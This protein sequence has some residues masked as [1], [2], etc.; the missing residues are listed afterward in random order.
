[1]RHRKLWTLVILLVALTASTGVPVIPVQSAT[2]IVPGA[3]LADIPL[4]SPIVEVIARLGAP[5]QVRLVAN[6]GTLAY[7]FGPYAITAYTRSNVVA[8]LATTNSVLAS[9]GGV[10]LGA[11]L[12]AVVAAFGRA[13][14][15]GV[16]EG[17]RGPVYENLGVAFGLDRDAV[18]AV[19][20]FAA[21][22]GPMSVPSPNPPPLPGAA[23]VT[24]HAA[25][26]GAPASQPIAAQ[27]TVSQLPRGA[28][29]P[30]PA[31]LA[32]DPGPSLANAL[33][34]VRSLHP[35]TAET[36]Y[37]S[38]AGYLR[39]L[40]FSMTRTWVVPDDSARLVRETVTPPSP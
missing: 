26:I 17:L 12:S 8:A 36:K 3:S 9:V 31:G 10:G 33:P 37:L 30:L 39:Y 38:L 24:S 28:S 29:D 19:I 13:R 6:D 16:V 35:Y 25:P 34:D 18:A 11:P 7:V 2:P 15:S 5:S 21:V 40:V 23:P 22:P 1:M 4:G 14:T 27:G 32:R 20:V